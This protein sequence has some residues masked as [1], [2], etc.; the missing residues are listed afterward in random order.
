MISINNLENSVLQIVDKIKNTVKQQNPDKEILLTISKLKN[1]I[2]SEE[3][4]IGG[5][6]KYK[7]II[8]LTIFYNLSELEHLIYRYNS[9]IEFNMPKEASDESVKLLNLLSDLD[10]RYNKVSSKNTYNMEQK[11]LEVMDL[12][13]SHINFTGRTQSIKDLQRGLN[14]LNKNRRQSSMKEKILLDKDGIFGNKTFSCFNNL[15]KNYTPRIIVKYIK[16]GA[17]NNAIFSTKNDQKINTNELINN[18]CNNFK[19]KE[20][21]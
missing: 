18:I 14:I 5:L 21:K 12:L 17:I 1:S 13:Q 11:M 4:E 15:C 9:F 2:F 6:T 3:N 19:L 20:A 7:R 8:A 16:K 10:I